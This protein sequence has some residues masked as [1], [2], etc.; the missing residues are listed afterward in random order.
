M[1]RC[2]ASGL[3]NAQMRPQALRPARLRQRLFQCVREHAAPYP[4]FVPVLSSKAPP[5]LADGLAEKE[6]RYAL[7]RFAPNN[8]GPPVTSPHWAASRL[9]KGSVLVP[10]PHRHG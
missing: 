2:A 8:L 1:I 9:G 5:E 7:R 4:S 6:F 10:N 3:R